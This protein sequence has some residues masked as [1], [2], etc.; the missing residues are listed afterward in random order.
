MKDTIEKLEKIPFPQDL[1][2]DSMRYDDPYFSVGHLIQALQNKSALKNI[3]KIKDA[4]FR[5]SNRFPKFTWIGEYIG[6]PN[7]GGSVLGSYLIRTEDDFKNWLFRMALL[8]MPRMNTWG[9]GG[10]SYVDAWDHFR[11]IFMGQHVA[12]LTAPKD[13]Y[14][15]PISVA[16]NQG[17]CYECGKTSP[18]FWTRNEINEWINSH[19]WL[20]I[21]ENKDSLKL[22]CTECGK[23]LLS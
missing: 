10:I 8:Q 5:I 2:F 16:T 22:V 19:E 13:E 17:K 4:Y 15:F 14:I 11:V 9:P 12:M 7:D 18:I 1:T 20:H 23:K 3:V 21:A 6:G